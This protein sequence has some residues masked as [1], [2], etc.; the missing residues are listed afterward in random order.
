M[1]K[2]Y[3]KY[4]TAMTVIKKTKTFHDAQKVSQI[5]LTLQLVI[6]L[7]TRQLVHD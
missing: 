4:F 3:R 2:S 1:H 6:G 5:T 7:V